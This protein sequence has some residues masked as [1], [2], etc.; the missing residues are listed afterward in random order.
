MDEYA[1]TL[2]AER[3]SMISGVAQV[4]VYGA[5]KYAVRVQFDPKVLAAR[6]IG[7][8]EAMQAIQQ[9]NVNLPTG[10]LYGTHKAF[11]V[12]A[13]GQL[14]QAA[15]YR[16]LIVAYRSGS[17]VRLEALGRVMDS[18]QN[19][20]VA[21]W[22]NGKRA[23]VIAIQRQP[24]TNTVEVVNNIKALLPTF[25]AEI[26]ASIQLATLYDRS[27][28][29][30]DSIND[31]KF[32]LWLTLG[33]VVLVIFIFL[34]NISATAIPSLALPMSIIGT[35]AVM[36]LL[37]YTLDNLSMMALVLSVGFVVDDAIVMLENIVRHME[38]GEGVF[39]AALNGSREISFTILSMTLSLAAVFI[40]VLFMGGLLGRLLHEFSVT[41]MC[42]VIVSG[43]VSLTLTP[44]LSSRFLRPPKEQEHGHL[45]LLFERGFQLIQRAYDWSLKSVLRHRF[46][47]LMA[48]LV[49]V[50][51]TVY[52]FMQIPKGFLPSEDAGQMF[53][54]TMAAQGISFDSMKQHQLEVTKIICSRSKCF[55]RDFF[56]RRGRPGWW[57]QLRLFLRPL[58]GSP[59]GESGNDRFDQASSAP[60]WRQARSQPSL[61]QHG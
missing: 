47:T 24:G 23:M 54:V 37:N 46:A 35:F 51:L 8:D 21:N 26:P 52:L 25:R 11:V 28:S 13:T 33:L 17:P 27:I 50:V 12:Q 31:V 15:A 14:M 20:K 39:A 7:I 5:Q 44:M 49:I 55:G 41:I 38:M 59:L 61:H 34:R 29:I 19:D 16:P 18:V 30:R 56:R 32:T 36:Y 43:V 45:Y 3:I 2:M 60:S 53:G 6:R 1:E 4:Q 48:S 22:F 10:T 9:A 40:P 42:A 58:E 57:R